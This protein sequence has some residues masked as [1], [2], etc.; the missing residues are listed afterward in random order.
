MDL[1]VVLVVRDPREV[2]AS[3]GVRDQLPGPRAAQLWLAHVL[4]AATST[5]GLR[6]AVV[7]YESALAAP[8][9]AIAEVAERL[10]LALHCDTGAIRAF[11]DAGLRHHD[12]TAVEAPIDPLAAEVQRTLSAS[13]IDE[14]AID[15]L[16]ARF[17]RERS[18]YAAGLEERWRGEHEGS[19]VVGASPVAPA[20]EV[21][22][23]AIVAM[24]AALGTGAATGDTPDPR[25]YLAGADAAFREEESLVAALEPVDRGFRARFDLPPG[26]A[27]DWIRFDPA[28]SPGF[29]VLER[30]RVGDADV[31]IAA[32]ARVA[33]GYPVSVRD[34]FGLVE[35]SHDP[36]WC[37]DVRGLGASGAR[38]ELWFRVESLAALLDALALPRRMAALETAVAATV[39][40]AH[41]I[42][43]SLLH[44][45]GETS[46]RL[47]DAERRAIQA[48][49]QLGRAIGLAER[50]LAAIAE[51]DARA[52]AA[53]AAA[54][55]SMASRIEAI[56]RQLGGLAGKVSASSEAVER[57]ERRSTIAHEWR[58]LRAFILGAFR[59]R[60]A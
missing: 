26:R 1:R 17:E 13:P 33:G 23:R 59:S 19:S 41:G 21:S 27:A 36:H 58:R 16:S 18:L 53:A 54:D 8:S 42:H 20:N 55:A 6:R 35:P 57:L 50:V 22:Q 2:Q 14:T 7:R 9:E 24:L 52:S 51:V 47:V 31:A 56:E 28:H 45:H 48:E 60:G 34:G 3:L 11:I 46:H 49:Q 37:I 25:L 40:H 32:R 12:A 5:R 44:I 43:A 38:I 4:E 39:E 10:D 15:Q 29:Y 30:L